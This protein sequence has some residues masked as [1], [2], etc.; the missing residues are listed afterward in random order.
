ME[1][2]VLYSGVGGTDFYAGCIESWSLVSDVK[3]TEGDSFSTDSDGVSVV[4]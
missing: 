4:W 1:R 2:A 3:I